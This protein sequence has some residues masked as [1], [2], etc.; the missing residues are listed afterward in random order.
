[1]TLPARVDYA[2]RALLGL[3]R[4]APAP[5]KAATLARDAGIPRPYL[6]DVL[7][8]LR[9]ANLVRAQRG[10]YGGYALSRPPDQITL[11]DVRR[12][13]DPPG[14]P[15]PRRADPLGE[16]LSTLWG[17]ADDA[18]LRVLD[19]VSIADL[20]SGCESTSG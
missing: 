16:R 6:Y 7:A 18:T 10:H 17:A 20:L 13:L 5:A 2:V 4:S 9:R 3:A 8:E 14:P 12:V 19:E 11:A 15:A 1:M